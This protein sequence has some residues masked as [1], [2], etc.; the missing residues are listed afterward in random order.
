MGFVHELDDVEVMFE[1]KMD[2]AL[3]TT[4]LDFGTKDHRP[5]FERWQG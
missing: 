3:R 4:W 5:Q 2:R 1:F